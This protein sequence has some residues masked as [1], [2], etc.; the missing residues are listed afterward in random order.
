M[1]DERGFTLFEVLVATAIAGLA[2]SA[3]YGLFV[4]GCRVRAVVGARC[5]RALQARYL[6]SQVA[7][8]VAGVSSVTHVLHGSADRFE[9]QVRG[10]EGEE[11]VTAVLE[12]APEGTD[13]RSRLV[14]AGPTALQSPLR[15]R[16]IRYLTA[17][18]TWSERWED[19][20]TLPRALLLELDDAPPYRVRVAGAEAWP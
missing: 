16:A 13:L 2:I 20:R 8:A 9:L 18:G 5:E 3:V 14:G 1:K 17:R 11:A 4:G 15:L 6:A 19:E 7:D 12:P 10:R